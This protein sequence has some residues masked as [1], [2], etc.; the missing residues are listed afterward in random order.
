ML[1]Y[2]KNV[3]YR[4]IAPGLDVNELSLWNIDIPFWQTSSKEQANAFIKIIREKIADSQ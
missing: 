4:F 3:K 2:F 1:I